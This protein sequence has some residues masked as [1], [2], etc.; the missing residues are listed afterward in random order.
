MRDGRKRESIRFYWK[1]NSGVYFCRGEYW[2]LMACGRERCSRSLV[3]INDACVGEERKLRDG[4]S[5]EKKDLWPASSAKIRG[6]AS[7]ND[8]A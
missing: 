2:D 4:K 7:Q 5:L 8:V 6:V 1:G 3:K